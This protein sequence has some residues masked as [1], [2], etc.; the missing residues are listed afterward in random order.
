MARR[1]P[2]FSRT[3]AGKESLATNLR[4]EFLVPP[5][6]IGSNQGLASNI[7]DG[8]DAEGSDDF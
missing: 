1:L 4:S 7:D 8:A 5:G 6:S 2:Q 3:K